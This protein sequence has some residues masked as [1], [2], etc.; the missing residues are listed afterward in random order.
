MDRLGHDLHS[1]PPSH[2]PLLHTYLIAQ[3]HLGLV[4][5]ESWRIMTSLDHWNPAC[6]WNH[7]WKKE[8]IKQQKEKLGT[9]TATPK[10]FN[11]RL[12]SQGGYRYR[13]LLIYF[14]EFGLILC[15][16]TR[17]SICM[18]YSFKT[19][20]F[21][22]LKE[23]DEVNLKTENSPSFR[24]V[25]RSLCVFVSLHTCLSSSWH[26]CIQQHLWK[27]EMLVSPEIVACTWKYLELEF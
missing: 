20:P 22:A 13:I 21:V 7:I 24:V 6:I 11:S 5:T 15:K 18:I 26:G 9:F 10:V 8:N 19:L 25:L 4:I 12:S 27:N 3:R 16:E 14:L 2:Q 1:D 17:R 23:K